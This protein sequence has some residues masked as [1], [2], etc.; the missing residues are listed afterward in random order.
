MAQDFTP[1][2]RSIWSD[3]D[4]R[5]LTWGG[6]WAYEMLASHPSR[7]EAGV[8]P[9]TKRKWL[10]LAA[11]V[12]AEQ[13]DAAL[14]ELDEAGFIVLDEDTQ[15]VLVRAFIRRT[16][17]YTHIRMMAN[18]LRHITEVESE[19]IRSAFGQELVRIPCLAIPE[20][21]QDGRNQQ[22]IDE[23]VAAQQRLDELASMLCDSPPDPPGQTAA[24][25]MG[26]PMADPMAH[27][28]VV[29]VGA[30]AGVGAGAVGGSC[31]SAEKESLESNAHAR[32]LT[33][34]CS[35]HPGKPARNCPGC[36]ADRKAAS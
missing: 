13:L 2:Y 5:A 20:L 4:W 24:H 15:E 3:E 27:G 1:W 21:R 9:V 19:R 36:A 25:P 29:V 16:K 22:A 18:A 6:Q 32:K 35:E 26:H 23:A 34:L 7:N 12:T 17:V 33:G 28:T 8:L 10:R 11:G 31:T 14:E 30:V